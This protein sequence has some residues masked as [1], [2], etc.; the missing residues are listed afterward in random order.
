MWFAWM[1]NPIGEF[2]TCL[3]KMLAPNL[4]VLRPINCHVPN[5]PFK[6]WSPKL[7]I[8]QENLL[9]LT[10]LKCHLPKNCN[11][12]TVLCLLPSFYRYTI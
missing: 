3:A 8:M 9:G 12:P 11:A 1:M 7:F 2:E 5:V 10:W 4:G 6:T